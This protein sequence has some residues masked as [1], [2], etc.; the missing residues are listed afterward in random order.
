MP[1]KKKVLIVTRRELR[2]NKLINWVSEIYVQILGQGGVLPVLVPIA[3]GTIANLSDYLEDYDGI[4]MSEGGDISPALYNEPYSVSKLDE[5]DPIK[6][7]IEITCC[8][9]AV[10]HNK[11]VLGFC[12]GMHMINVVFGGSLHLD[13]H[14]IN[15]K[16]VL[17]IDYDN[18]DTVRHPIAIAEDTP[19]FHWYKEKEIQVNTYHHQ[20][21]KNLGEG[22][23]PM[24]KAP[25]GLIEGVFHPDYKF[26]VGLQFHPERMYQEY[27]G[28]KLVFKSFIDAL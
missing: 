21:I 1:S 13:I 14:E 19:L 2:K 11:P 26:V 23:I 27:A 8:R 7:E 18:Y 6:D 10:E 9:H 28:N 22:L 15:K 16:S 20:G 17:H 5:Y 25:D 4:L 3:Q 24:A 12:R